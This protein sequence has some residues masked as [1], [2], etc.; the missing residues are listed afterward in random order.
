MYTLAKRFRFSAAHT[1][2]SPVL[3]EEENRRVYGKCANPTGHGHDYAI[4][5]IVSGPELIEDV[6]VGHGWLDD[7]VEQHLV[8]RFRFQ[9]LNDAFRDGFITTGENLTQAVWE[10]LEPQLPSGLTLTVRLVETSKNAFVFRG[11][12]EQAGDGGV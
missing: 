10:L 7:L 12:R 4:E 3:S 6:V 2:Y 9:N 8:P 5:V 1:L 11:D